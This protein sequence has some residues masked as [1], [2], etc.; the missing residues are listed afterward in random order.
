M[1]RKDFEV[2]HDTQA[3][4]CCANWSEVD[5]QLTRRHIQYGSQHILYELIESAVGNTHVYSLSQKSFGS[6]DMWI[7]STRSVQ[8]ARAIIE[9]KKFWVTW[10]VQAHS[11]DIR[12]QSKAIPSYVLWRWYFH[13]VTFESTQGN[14]IT[15]ASH[16]QEHPVIPIHWK[17]I[18][19]STLTIYRRLPDNFHCSSACLVP[20]SLLPVNHQAITAF[21]N[22][23]SSTHT[24]K[25]PLATRQSQ[26]AQTHARTLEQAYN[27]PKA[28]TKSRHCM[29]VQRHANSHIKKNLKSTCT[30]TQASLASTHDHNHTQLDFSYHTHRL[31]ACGTTLIW[32]NTYI[33]R[34]QTPLF[35][36]VKPQ[37]IAWYQDEF[38][39]IFQK[40]LPDVCECKGAGQNWRMY[41]KDHHSNHKSVQQEL[42][43]TSH[44]R[45]IFAWQQ[46]IVIK[47]DRRTFA[48]HDLIFIW[49]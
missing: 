34:A 38:I 11:R 9:P 16:V 39:I 2:Q 17:K 18:W 40:K 29:H 35:V 26:H 21:T 42:I 12:K 44:E 37:P 10:H 20:A 46:L 27:I 49:M 47:H 1:I 41:Q 36:L 13:R 4:I 30:C 48:K 28:S 32:Q 23:C 8:H 43:V 31:V 15:R 22:H 3:C 45:Q 14:S 24:L 6:R 25:Y 33:T 5:L 19:G 7:D